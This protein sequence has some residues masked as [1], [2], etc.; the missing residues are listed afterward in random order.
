MKVTLQSRTVSLALY[1]ANRRAYLVRL[2]TALSVES[3]SYGDL[4]GEIVGG[5]F[6]FHWDDK[7]EAFFDYGP[8]ASDGKLVREVLMRCRKGTIYEIG[9][10]CTRSS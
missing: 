3:L 8:H 7:E 2:S 6:E 10:N 9:M 4:H 5:L 1:F